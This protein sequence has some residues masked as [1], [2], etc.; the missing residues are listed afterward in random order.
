MKS[1][2]LSL[3]SVFSISVFAQQQEV[4]PTHYS[5]SALEP[6]LA[7]FYHGV[8]SGDPLPDAVVIWT[9]IT[10]NSTDPVDVN[11]RMATDTLFSNIVASGMATTDSSVDWTINVDVTGL[12]PDSWYYYDFE[13]NGDHSL[14]GRTHTAPVGGV[15]HLRFAVLS[16]QNYEHGYYHAYR[17]LAGRNDIDCI[18]FL[19]DYIYEYEVGGYSA[20]I[21]GRTNEPV[22]EIISLSDYRTRYSLYKLDPDLRDAHQQYP[23]IVIWDDHES[24]NNSYTDGAQNHTPATEGPWSDRKAHSIQANTEWLPVRLPDA[25]HPEKRF[26]KFEFGDLAELEMLDTRLYDRDEQGSGSDQDR[27]LMGYEQRHWLYDNLEN[28]TT[29]WKVIGQQVMMAPLT[30][31]GFPINNDQ[32]D[33]YPAERDSLFNFIA[34]NNIDNTVVLTGDI[35]TSWANDLPG[36]NYDSNTGSGS[37]GVEYVV[38]SVTSSSFPIPVGQ[39]LIMSVNPHIKYADLTQK[40]YLILDLTDTI[41]QSDWYFVSDVTVPT[42]TSSLGTSWFTRDGENHLEHASAPTVGD[43]YPP[44]A[45]VFEPDTSTGIAEIENEPVII[46]AYP[47]PFFDRFVVQFNLFQPEQV[48]IRLTDISG[49]MIMEKD[50]G[51]LRNGLQYLQVNTSD[52]PAG[53]YIF[54]LQTENAVVTRRMTRIE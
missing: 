1:L 22:N 20:N 27:S 6:E 50:L 54:T 42:H 53:L 38:T 18:L 30:A 24:A 32:W 31:F 12:D 11:W 2:L 5:R 10:L 33:G 23:F 34:T 39:N 13:Y 21:S 15:D 4:G 52:L 45:P 48:R 7:P 40:G 37:V 49:K 9:R 26:R 44:L 16:C 29:K 25:N 19:G 3:L 51:Q 14:I 17:D 47:N 36:D 35:H 41:A 43:S 8:A 28:A 46:G